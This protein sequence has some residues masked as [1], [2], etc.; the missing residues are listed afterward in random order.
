M[1]ADD[2][3][4]PLLLEAI[5]AGG[6]GAHDAFAALY[7]RYR[8]W[9]F[10]VARRAC[11]GDDDV[12]ADMTQEVFLY[13]LRRLPEPS[14]TLGCQL[15]TYLYPAIRHVALGQLQRRGRMAP[16]DEDA[17]PLAA[18]ADPA[19]DTDALS[20]LLA[21]LPSGQRE[22][23]LLRFV[24]GLPLAEIAQALGVPLGTVKSRLHLALAAL[25]EDPATH[26][27]LGP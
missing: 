25:R 2:R 6:R 22:V 19:T 16:L 26:D 17:A 14:F 11:R 21:R 5:R 23:L 15:K 18:P 8:D 1:P 3:P 24:D 10:A 7:H 20:A 9:V 13:L 27:L 12:A 4:D